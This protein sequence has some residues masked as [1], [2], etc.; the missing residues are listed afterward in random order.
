[1]KKLA[2][3]FLFVA[4]WLGCFAMKGD[5]NGDGTVTSTDVTALYNFLL[6]N[7][8]SSLVNGDVNGDGNIEN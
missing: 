6:Y 8:T 2:L 4:T 1:M 7:D 3:S 5:V